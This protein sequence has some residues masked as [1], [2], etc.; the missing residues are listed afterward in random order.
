[1]AAE[2]VGP[3]PAA[4]GPAGP[5]ELAEL[6]AAGRLAA[7]Y[8]RVP[9]LL[10]GVTGAELARAGR[11]LARLDPEEIARAH[12]GVPACTVA[13]TGHGTVA[14][15]VPDLTAELARHGMLLRSHLTPFGTYVSELLDPASGLYAAE[16]DLALCVL[17]GGVVFDEVPVPWTPDD[18][19]RTARQKAALLR[20][21]A[22]AFAAAGRGTLVLNTVPLERRY[23]AQLVDHRARARLGVVWREFNTA[24]LELA[25]EQPGVVVLDLDP[26]VGAAGAAEDPR[27]SVYAKA[28]LPAEVLT[29]YAREAGHLARHLAGRTGKCLVLDLDGTLWGGTLGDDGP[30]GIQVGEG[31]RGEAFAGFQRVVRQLGSQGVLLAAVSKNDADLVRSTL[32]DHPGMVLREDDFVRVVANWRPKPD[33]LAELAADLGLGV[34]GLVFVDD[35]PYERGLVAHRLP[36]VAVVAVDGEPAWHAA[37]LLRDG[38]FDVVELTREDTARPARYRAELDRRDFSAGFDSLDDYLREL[39]VRVDIAPAGAAD[40]ARVSQLT[41]RTNQFNLTTRRLSPGEVAALAG[42]P[43]TPVLTVRAADRFGDNGLV[44]AVFLRRRGGVLHIDNFLLSCRVFARGIEQACMAA[45][46]LH[47]RDSGAREV[48]ADYRPTP[49]NAGA[50][51]FYPR[52]GFRPADDAGGADGALLFR[53]DLRRVVPPPGHV[54]LTAGF[55]APEGIQQ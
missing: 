31:P 22:A 38:W 13:I 37:R 19:E 24:L 9:G 48:L 35:S 49:R 10:S 11:L 27:P 54:R 52:Q 51:E 17:D 40:A 33:N 3:G 41:L 53:H 47:A 23:T 43:D 2:P 55:A 4:T 16:P 14:G 18:V 34:G 46:L 12:P 26:L 8:P 45:V 28:H 1:M 42:D 39:G 15:L 25:A 5:A 21:L 50:R 6:A 29:G 7:E 20:G 44:G 30:D 36:E 32:R